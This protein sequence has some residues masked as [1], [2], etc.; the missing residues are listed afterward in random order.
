MSAERDAMRPFLASAALLIPLFIG[1]C[2]KSSLRSDTEFARSTF[3]ALA[4]GDIAVQNKI[5]WPILTASGI[6]VGAQYNAIPTETEKERFRLDFITQ[7]ASSFRESG[8]SVDNFTNWKV[9]FSDSTRTE[10][11]ADSG[12]GLLTLTVGER[13][14]V[15]RIS[16]ITTSK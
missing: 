1:S 12:G 3:S 6:N 11:T 16:S 14:S 8:A 2:E 5:D 4:K 15:Q 9:T 7:F 10:V 13:D